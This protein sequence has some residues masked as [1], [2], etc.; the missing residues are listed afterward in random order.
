ILGKERGDKALSELNL[1]GN[2]KK[3]PD[4]FEKSIFLGNV[5]MTYNKKTKSFISNGTIGVANLFKN[6]IYRQVPGYI[7]I[8]KQKA[9]DMLDMY[10]ELDQGTWYY[11]NYFKGVMSV[12]SSNQ[13]FNTEVK[14]VK[15]K[16]QKVDKGPSYQFNVCSPTKKDLFVK[17]LKQLTGQ[18]EED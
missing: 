16:K 14:D 1:Y 12:V 4:E 8:K 10:F 7:Q 11:F 18:K 5:Q 6:E 3:F 13:A 17:K 9:G 15:E 2:Y